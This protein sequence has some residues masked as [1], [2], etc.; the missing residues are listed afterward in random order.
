ML[1]AYGHALDKAPTLLRDGELISDVRNATVDS[2][3]SASALRFAAERLE[4]RGADIIY[5]AWAGAASGRSMQ[6]DTKVA[7]KLLDDPQLR[8][9]ASR[10]LAVALELADARGCADY[11]R[12]LSKVITDGD[13]RCLRTLRRLTYDR[14]CGL[15]GLGDCYSCLRGNSALAQAIE[16]AKSRLSPTF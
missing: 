16:A 8:K 4:S 6:V 5:N 15:F 9:V 10:P 2:A 12:A 7:K 11:R 1:E 3:T 13:E 14:G